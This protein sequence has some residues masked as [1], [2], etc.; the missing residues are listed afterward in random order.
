MVEDCQNAAVISSGEAAEGSGKSPN[1]E[2]KGGKTFN[3]HSTEFKPKMANQGVA[4]PVA[5][6]EKEQAVGTEAAP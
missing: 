3:V 1:E 4:G 2:S 5:D 6:A